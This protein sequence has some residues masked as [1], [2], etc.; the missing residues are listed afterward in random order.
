MR[1]TRKPFRRPPVRPRTVQPVPLPEKVPVSVSPELKR[2]DPTATGTAAHGV[3]GWLVALFAVASGMTVANLY[4]AQPLL[5]SLRDV[6]H[7]GTAAAAWTHHPHPGRLRPGHA[8]PGA[9][10]RPAGEAQADHRAADGDHPRPG[11]GRPRH[12]LP[13]AADRVPDQRKHLGRRPDPDPLRGEPRPRSRPRPDRRPGDERSA[14]RHTALPHPEQSGLRR[15]RAGA[16]STSAP[17]S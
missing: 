12:E 5:S 6:F 16:W 4:Y 3:P 11:R 1:A 17:P 15:G 8:L 13:D 10:R 9:A 2:S 7:V 14:H